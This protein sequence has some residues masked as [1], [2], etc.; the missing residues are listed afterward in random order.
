MEQTYDQAPTDRRRW[1]VDTVTVKASLAGV[2]GEAEL[3]RPAVGEPSAHGDLATALG[4][5]MKAALR[6][7]AGLLLTVDER[8]RRRR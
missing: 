3:R 4:S 1:A 2:G 7:D 8:R 6:L 5:A